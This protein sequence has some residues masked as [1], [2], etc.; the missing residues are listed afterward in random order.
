[1]KGYVYLLC[2]GQ[3]F[4]IGMTKQKNIYKRIKEL[5]TGNPSEIWLQNF[6]ETNNP[7]KIEQ[8]MHAKY[9]M[10][11]VK[12][13]WFDLSAKDVANFKNE[14]LKCEKILEILKDNPFI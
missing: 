10:F 13:E 1:M 6:Y 14:C 5:Q 3:K 2:D 4:K 9:A 7:L 8:L 11:N 12:N